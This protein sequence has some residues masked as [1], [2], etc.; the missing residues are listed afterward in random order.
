MMLIL[1]LFFWHY[2]AMEDT[3]FM[4]VSDYYCHNFVR[5][6]HAYNAVAAIYL[7]YRLY[8]TIFEALTLLV[9]V[10]AILHFS[11]HRS[12]DYEA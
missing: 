4:R 11:R 6:T 12:S 2:M 10:L 7:N 3:T 1:A 5:D 8:D 9:S